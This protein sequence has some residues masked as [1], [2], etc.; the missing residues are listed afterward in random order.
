MSRK[1][2]PPPK[3][4]V[5]TEVD[6]YIGQNESMRQ[7]TLTQLFKNDPDEESSVE[8]MLTPSPCLK[9]QKKNINTGAN[10]C[11]KYREIR[12]KTF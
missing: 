2:T 6:I 1:V 11:E 3:N 8:E 7:T 10:H 9:R 5:P 4:D 12:W